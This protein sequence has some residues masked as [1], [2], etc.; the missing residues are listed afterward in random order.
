M[1]NPARYEDMGLVDSRV[2][3][4]LSPVGRST[5]TVLMAAMIATATVSTAGIAVPSIAH[6]APQGGAIQTLESYDAQ[7]R[8]LVEKQDLV[9]RAAA[10]TLDEASE[11]LILQRELVRRAGYEQLSELRASST[12]ASEFL[13]WF[14]GDLAAL[15]YYVTGGEVWTNAKNNVATHAD[16]IKSLGIFMRLRKTNAAD[17]TA[18]G[19][20]ADVY[21]RMM[22]AASLDVSGRARLWTG[23]PGFVS[24]PLVRYYTIKTFRSDERYR[25]KKDLFDALPVESMRLV[26]EN[27]ITDAELPWLANYSLAKFSATD[28]KTEDSRLNAYSYIWYDGGY[29]SNGGYSNVRFYNDAEFNGPVE[30]MKSSNGAPGK[31][32]KVWQGGWKEKYQLSYTD[33]HFPNAEANDLYHIGC[34]DVSSVPGATQD[35]TK[36][37]RL[38]MVF[39]KGGV[40]GALAKTFANLNGMVGVPSFVVGQPGHAATLTYELRADANGTMVPT[41]RIQND[42]SGWG[43]SKSPSAAHWLNGWGRGITGEFAGMYTLYATE[44]LSDWVGYVRSYETRL[45]AASLDE[46]STVREQAIDAAR[47]AQPINFDALWAKIELLGARD[48]AAAEWEAL[49]K[50]IA[51]QLKFYPLPMHDLIKNI[52]KRTDGS[53]FAALEAIRLDALQRAS[54]VDKSQTVNH[55]ACARVAKMLMG[56]ADGVVA[57]FSFDGDQTGVIALGEH[58]RGGGVPWRFSLDGGKT[59]SDQTDGQVEVVLTADQIASIN[60]ETDIQIQLIG[61]SVIN[62]IDI[63]A[64]QAP[65]L[66]C[67]ANDRANRIYFFDGKVPNGLEMR[68]DGGSWE[69]LDVERTYKGNRT[70]ELRVPARGTTTAS[71]PAVFTFTAGDRDANFVPYEEMVVNSYSSSRDGAAMAQRVIDGY[72]GP[73]NEFWITSREKTS[74]AWIVLDLGH[75]RAVTDV[76]YWRPKNLGTNGVPRWDRMAVTVSVAPDTGL[77]A[78][79]P[80]DASAF[81][82]VERFGKGGTKVP[83]WQESTLSTRL[84]L[85]DGPVMARYVKLHLNDIYFSATLIDVWEAHEPGLEADEVVFDS[86]REGEET[87]API[88]LELKNT[89]KVDVQIEGVTL[90][91]DAFELRGS[92]STMIPAGG[93]D[94]SWQVVPKAGLAVGSHRAAAKVAYRAVGTEATAR[95]LSIPLMIE[96]SP[97]DVSVSVDVEKLGQDSVRLNARVEGA[98]G[99][100]ARVEYALCDTNQAPDAVTVADTTEGPQVQGNPLNTWTSDPVFSGLTPGETYYA[101]V[102]VTGVPG[103]GAVTSGEGAP[104]E[105]VPDVVDPDGGDSNGGNGGGDTGGSNGDNQGGDQG[106]DQGDGNDNGDAGNNGDSGNDGSGGQETPDEDGNQD[107]NDG[108]KDESGDETPQNSLGSKPGTLPGTGDASAHGVMASAFAGVAS[109]AA[110]AFSRLR[111]RREDR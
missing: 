99:L 7:I 74:D 34:G 45:I 65:S 40:C 109:M 38:W 70:V 43:K 71:N 81:K 26:F 23:D 110:A 80:V 62:C 24:D 57:T 69:P 50:E 46:G 4:A 10:G 84:T 8:S 22:V 3:A 100:G 51:E 94:A 66:K 95:T 16:Y 83:G 54:K 63:V 17:L 67:E 11:R 60:A 102:R 30:E 27:Q 82:E 37:H 12:D 36:Y 92:G 85:S 21:L 42:V 18:P 49:A 97:A 79:V 64:G 53:Q 78:G 104:V 106:G 48:A 105:I 39:E 91:S 88:A 15:R 14:M 1:T 75:E 31:P 47:G 13:D 101:F 111:S 52:N 98:E 19:A 32:L 9:A 44:A 61:A 55:D 20:D 5:K 33:A 108:A 73:G 103:L 90:D 96:V 6:A 89:S 25:F 59:W 72:Y 87:P 77:A 93:T 35:K 28:D 29:A 2:R 41:Y 86:M 56:E 76:D 107:D 58:L 68:V